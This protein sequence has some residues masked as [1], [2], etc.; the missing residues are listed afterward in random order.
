MFPDYNELVDMLSV[1][2]PLIVAVLMWSRVVVTIAKQ[3]LFYRLLQHGFIM[4]FKDRNINFSMIK[5]GICNGG[6][7]IVGFKYLPFV[8]LPCGMVYFIYV[9]ISHAMKDP[10]EKRKDTIYALIITQLQ[11]VTLVGMYYSD[12]IEQ[13]KKLTSTNE[14]LFAHAE[15]VLENATTD[16][17]RKTYNAPKSASAES[18]SKIASRDIAVEFLKG[19]A[20][21]DEIDV[22]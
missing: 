5:D 19:L 11:W 8:I 14:L 7:G 12:I 22:R 9:G 13:E 17:L 15:K 6:G 2:F 18:L 3:D 16:E 10:P 4:D 20:V 21:L 1:L